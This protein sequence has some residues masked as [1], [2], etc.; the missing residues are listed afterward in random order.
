MLIGLTV[1]I[2]GDTSSIP[3]SGNP[4]EEEMTTN[5]SILAWRVP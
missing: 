5:S 4:L 2:A 1:V 3:V